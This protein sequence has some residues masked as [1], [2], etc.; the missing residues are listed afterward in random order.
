MASKANCAECSRQGRQR[1]RELFSA[2]DYQKLEEQENNLDKELAEARADLAQESEAMVKS[3]AKVNRL[4]K[5]QN[6]L[7]ERGARM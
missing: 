7:I 3:L 5:Q 4:E 2:G 6:F 1:R